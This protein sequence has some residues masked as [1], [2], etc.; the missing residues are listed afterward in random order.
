MS[1][2]EE[3][4]IQAAIDCIE[5]YG[6]KDTTI[7]RIGEMAG[8]NSAAVSYYFRS[9]DALIDRALNE[10]LENAFGWKDFEYTE[11]MPLKQQLYEIF[12][13]FSINT[14]RFPKLT[15]A[16]FYEIIANGNYDTKPTEKINAFLEKIAGEVKRKKPE[17][18]DMKIKLSL[19]QL[20]AATLLFFSTFADIFDGFS[21]LDM[22]DAIERK[23]YVMHLI[24]SLF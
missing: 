10:T 12:S 3:K 17:M 2:T 21:G 7:R 24:D 11:A 22:D 8:V 1:G 5:Q 15:Q 19:M 18:D 23:R 14:M 6:V 20:T 9:K 16:H 4:I 13:F